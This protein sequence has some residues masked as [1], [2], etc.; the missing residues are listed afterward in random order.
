MDS[1]NMAP[2]HRFIEHLCDRVGVLTPP[3]A[4]VGFPKPPLPPV[5]RV[6]QKTLGEIWTPNSVYV[7]CH[8]PVFFSTLDQDYPKRNQNC[9]FSQFWGSD[10]F[11]PTFCC[12]ETK[13]VIFTMHCLGSDCRPTGQT[14]GAREERQS[15]L[16]QFGTPRPDVMSPTDLVRA[17]MFQ[18]F[19]MFR[20][21]PP[22]H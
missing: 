2:D 21:V 20:I 14:L 11:G 19:R 3:P 8:T 13:R 1:A 5:N 10:F 4:W 18:L 15:F 6:V 9:A 16:S 22:Q 12:A 7:L 17:C